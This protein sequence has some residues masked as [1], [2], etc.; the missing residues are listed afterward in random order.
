[1][2][3]LPTDMGFQL[4]KV[5]ISAWMMPKIGNPTIN[6]PQTENKMANMG[7][8][9]NKLQSICGITS[10]RMAGVAAINPVATINNEKNTMK[11]MNKIGAAQTAMITNKALIMNPATLIIPRPIFSNT[12]RGLPDLI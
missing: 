2:I 4:A 3:L 1:M 7:E 11:R 8:A 6:I 10:D 5:L 9:V 12:E